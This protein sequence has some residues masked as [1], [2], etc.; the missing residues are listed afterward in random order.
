MDTLYEEAIYFQKLKRRDCMGAVFNE[1]HT[2]VPQY[3][4]TNWSMFL[5][6]SSSPARAKWPSSTGPPI[7]EAVVIFDCRC[8]R[9]RALAG[10]S[11]KH[12]VLWSALGVRGPPNSATVNR[13]CIRAHMADARHEIGSGHEIDM[14]P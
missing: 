9:L 5:F 2:S 13:R 10:C 14:S 11:N 3:S 7:V 1:I 6:F 12:F 8:S 4:R